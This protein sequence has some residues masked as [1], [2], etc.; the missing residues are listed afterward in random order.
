ME[1]EDVDEA[2]IELDLEERGEDKGEEYGEI[3]L[4]SIERV[5]VYLLL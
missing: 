4:D 3:L 2:A 1:R 5:E